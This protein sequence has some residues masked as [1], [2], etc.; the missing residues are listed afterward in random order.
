MEREE[1]AE[2]ARHWLL[3]AL[4]VYGLRLEDVL[5]LCWGDIDLLT[6]RLTIRPAESRI[7]VPPEVLDHLR[8]WPREGRPARRETS[9]G[10]GVTTDRIHRGREG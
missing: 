9:R 4:A 6:G 8:R 5:M 2:D 10:R 3:H 7:L 1:M